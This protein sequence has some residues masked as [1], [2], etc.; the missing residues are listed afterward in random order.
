MEVKN[1]SRFGSLQLRADGE[2]LVSRSGTALVPALADRLGLTSELSG[3]LQGLRRR[4]RGHDPGAVVRDLATMLIDGGECVSDIAALGEQ[5][6][7][8]G[9]LCSVSTAARVIKAIGPTELSALRRAR[10]SARRRAWEAGARP[11]EVVLDLDSHLVTAHSEKEDAAGNWKGGFGFH[12]LLCHLEG[13]TEALAGKLRPGNASAFDADDHVEVLDQALAQLPEG[14]AKGALVRTDAAGG[15]HRLATAARERGL[16]FSLGYQLT[17]AVR[18]AVL[19]LPERRW[20]PARESD[21]SIREG[22]WVA[23]LTESLATQREWPQG[24]RLICRKE[25]AHP[26][27][28]LSFGD[29]GGHRF[30]CFI[31]D[32]RTRSLAELEL[33]HRRRAREEDRIR[34]A[35]ELGL[36]R[37]PFHDF[38]ANGA[39][40]EL[41]LIAQDLLAWMRAL[42]LAGGLRLA[43]PKRLRHRLLH[44]AGRITRSARQTTLHLPRAWPWAAELIAAQ[45]RLR[46]VPAPA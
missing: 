46:A 22:A 2:G 19:A 11:A 30:Q 25:R 31:T 34:E 44:V 18:E 42:V 23:E 45:E 37:L 28:Q 15:S 3:A 4:Q 36:A 20:K 10:A 43:E 14:A 29:E 40:L 26:G 8:F 41:C 35:R 24:S 9:E 32:Q 21:G 1:A 7:L 39:W 16:C 33:R 27:A 13:S 6:D 38:A 17:E 5:P 12:P